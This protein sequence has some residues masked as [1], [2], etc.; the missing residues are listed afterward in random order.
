MAVVVVVEAGAEVEAEIEVNLFVH[1][2]KT[3]ETPKVE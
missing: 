1:S 3:R 2:Q